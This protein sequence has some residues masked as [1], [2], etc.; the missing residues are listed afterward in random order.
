MNTPSF[1]RAQIQPEAKAAL[2]AHPL[3]TAGRVP[4]S[5]KY[6]APGERNDEREA[7]LRGKDA[8]IEISPVLREKTITYKR[9]TTLV[10]D[11]TFSVAV[12][13]KPG[14]PAGEAPLLP[15][16]LDTMVDAAQA[17]LLGLGFRLAVPFNGLKP[18]DEL[19]Q[20]IED[21]PGLL[22][23][24]IFFTARCYISASAQ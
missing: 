13:I 21:E 8:L 1:S 19:S 10:K 2:E 3:F 14:V 24:A 17:A 22:S 11:C 18:E 6:F 5:L 4:V 12:R 16:T 20:L 9:P 15:L 7:L 23:T